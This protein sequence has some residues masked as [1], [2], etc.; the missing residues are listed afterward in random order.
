M[1][2]QMCFKTISK[3]SKVQQSVDFFDVYVGGQF[4]DDDK[5]VGDNM[6]TYGES[7]CS[8]RDDIVWLE[9]REFI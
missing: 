5:R 7:L 6:D 4:F 8:S 3:Q 1:I 2:F 9:K